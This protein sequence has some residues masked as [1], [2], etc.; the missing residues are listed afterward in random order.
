MPVDPFPVDAPRRA[1]RLSRSV[2]RLSVADTRKLAPAGRVGRVEFDHA[3]EIGY[4]RVESPEPCVGPRD[5]VDER[6]VVRLD[7]PQPLPR[8][9]GRLIFLEAA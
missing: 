1:R 7:L 9:E 2:P 6:R 4:R 3:F 5:V 8:V